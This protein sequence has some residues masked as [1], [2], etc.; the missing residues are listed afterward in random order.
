MAICAGLSILLACLGLFALSAYMT[1]RRTKEI[2]IRKAMGA[3]TPDVV[4][5]LLWQFTVP[6]L[7]AIAVAA[8]LG[9]FAMS[10]WLR[11]FAY[12]VPLS[13]WT[14]ALAAAAAVVIAWLTVSWQSYV[15]ARAKPAGALQYE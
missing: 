7:C 13:L 2:G 10:D 1:E 11:Q 9:F 6:V 5:L 15:I 14:V 12:R 8:P 3:G 4:A